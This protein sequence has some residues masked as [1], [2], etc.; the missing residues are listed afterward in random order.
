MESHTSTTKQEKHPAAFLWE[1][2]SPDKHFFNVAIVYSVAIS[3]LTLSVPIAVQTLINTL[4]NISSL[5]A[6]IILSILLFLGLSISAALSAMRTR[7]MEYFQRRIYARLTAEVSLHT[8]Y[9]RHEY[10]AGRRNTDITNRYFDIVVLQKNIPFLLVDGFALL[11]QM[12]VGFTLV[13]FY[14]PVLLMFNLGVILS[15]LLIW[16][17]WGHSAINT[18]VALSHAKYQTSK[19]LDS[20]AYAHEFFKST[21]HIDYALERT[22]QLTA[23]YVKTH[24]DHFKYTFSQTIA[25]LMLYAAASAA[26]LGIGGWLVTINQLSLGQL[27]AAELILAAILFG[28]S[29]TSE[30]LKFYYEMCGAADE[31]GKIFSIPQENIE[32][33]ANRTMEGSYLSFENVTLDNNPCKFNFTIP[34]KTKIVVHAENVNTQ[35]SF[36]HL[37]KRNIHPQSGAIQLAGVDFSDFDVYRLRQDIVVIDRA[38]IVE[39]T[40]EEYLDMSQ[41][42]SAIAEMRSVLMQVNIMDEIDKLPQGLK[43]LLSPLGDPLSPASFLQLKLAATLLTQPKILILTPFFDLLT[44]ESIKSIMNSISELPL[45]VLYFTKQD[46]SDSVDHQLQLG[47]TKQTLIAGKNSQTILPLNDPGVDRE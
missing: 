11:L 32:M 37:L 34:E 26:L 21:R 14:H 20:L 18:A 22:E 9:A 16:R 31:L 43:T 1:L 42:G 45:T 47:E 35:Y 15:L 19:W 12:I 7:T 40:I 23:E 6:I 13:S 3:I 28:L 2:I 10:F 27:I 30:Y 5:R 8:I 39:C 41:P 25:F 4:V 29:K 38:P 33:R 46:H 44:K 24:S 36:I 17:L